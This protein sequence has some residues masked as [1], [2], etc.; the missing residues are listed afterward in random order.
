M[1]RL[2]FFAVVAGCGGGGGRSVSVVSSSGRWRGVLI[3]SLTKLCEEDD[4]TDAGIEEATLTS[5]SF[6]GGGLGFGVDVDGVGFC[7]GSFG[8][9]L[10]AFLDVGGLEGGIADG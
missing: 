1:E 9:F 4:I 10:V 3:S 6:R 7:L 5:R 2:R 8:G